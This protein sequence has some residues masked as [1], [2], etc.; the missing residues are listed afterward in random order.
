VLVQAALDIITGFGWVI[1]AARL[2]YK[3]AKFARKKWREWKDAR[4]Q[5]LCGKDPQMDCC[6]N[7]VMAWYDKQVQV[8]RVKE[9]EFRADTQAYLAKSLNYPDQ[10]TPWSVTMF[11]DATD[12]ETLKVLIARE[13]TAGAPTIFAIG[14]RIYS[15][16]GKGFVRR[17]FSARLVVSRMSFLVEF[18]KKK[19]QKRA[20]V[21]RYNAA[22][23]DFL[24]MAGGRRDTQG[25]RIL[26]AKKKKTPLGVVFRFGKGFFKQRTFEMMDEKQSPCAIAHAMC[27]AACYQPEQCDNYIDPEG[28]IGLDSKA[29]EANKK[30][31]IPMCA[32]VGGLAR[33]NG[34]QDS[35]VVKDT[36][37]GPTALRPFVWQHLFKDGKDEAMPRT[38]AFAYAAAV[39]DTHVLPF[40]SCGTEECSIC[41]GVASLYTSSQ[42]PDDWCSTFKLPDSQNQS[43]SY[44]RDL[45]RYFKCHYLT[46]YLGSTDDKRRLSGRDSTTDEVCSS[47]SFCSEENSQ[48]PKLDMRPGLKKGTAAFA[49]S[50]CRLCI[51]FVQR[52]AAGMRPKQFCNAI[53]GMYTQQ[54][55][56]CEGTLHDMM[57]AV[58]GIKDAQERSTL[59]SWIFGWTSQLSG[60]VCNKYCQP[61]V[62][63][64]PSVR[65]S[66]KNP[67]PLLLAGEDTLPAPPGKVTETLQL[68]TEQASEIVKSPMMQRAMK[69]VSTR[70]PLSISASGPQVVIW[71][72]EDHIQ[73]S[74]SAWEAL[75]KELAWDGTFTQKRV[76]PRTSTQGLISRKV[77][78]AVFLM[79][80]EVT[81]LRTHINFISDILDTKLNLRVARLTAEDLIRRVDLLTDNFEAM[82]QVIDSISPTQVPS[83][84]RRQV[85]RK[86]RD[87]ETVVKCYSV[88]VARHEM[89]S[90]ILEELSSA[91][92]Q[93]TDKLM[94][95]RQRGVKYSPKDTGLLDVLTKFYLV[96]PQEEQTR[97]TRLKQW[98]NPFNLF[99]T[100]LKIDKLVKADAKDCSF[101]KVRKMTQ[102][103]LWKEF[104]TCCAERTRQVL[105]WETNI[106][107]VNMQINKILEMMGYVKGNLLTRN[108]R[109]VFK[110]TRAALL[111][112]EQKRSLWIQEEAADMLL[113]TWKDFQKS[114]DDE[115]AKNQERG[116]TFRQMTE[117][118][119]NSVGDRGVRR[120][121]FKELRFDVVK[122]NAQKEI[123]NGKDH[124][125]KIRGLLSSLAGRIAIEED[126]F[127][128]LTVEGIKERPLTKFVLVDTGA[129]EDQPKRRKASKWECEKEA[130]SQLGLTFKSQRFFRSS[131]PAGCLAGE[132][133]KSYFRDKAKGGACG[134]RYK[135]ICAIEP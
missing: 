35:T 88:V 99:R 133:S 69:S 44:A 95:A 14:A 90:P 76:W 131:S 126:N 94:E 12:N 83:K 46:G 127:P 24:P 80:K 112:I 9:A 72:L 51:E 15:R 122:R 87:R 39:C 16:F 17:T 49:D 32:P 113:G 123:Q 18:P 91:L 13:I 71:K 30:N 74:I 92:K 85:Q 40:W 7:S 105:G 125:S 21:L 109:K 60:N 79:L 58:P 73:S 100:R 124:F 23:E 4:K 97:F 3:L 11:S 130:S 50:Q 25:F 101:R 38:E 121:V 45:G 26:K 116:K 81:L 2:S 135:C 115:K 1:T 55:V 37:L 89:Y 104:Q 57:E 114:V 78:E 119:Y 20:R 62:K 53:P 33:A 70:L 48:L 84:L 5:T 64:K 19:R 107:T 110:Y 22:C 66:L 27:R 36:K 10:C 129:C 93:A 59:G 41:Q 82:S 77:R 128:E 102:S 134:T 68:Q 67:S 34:V 65:N 118:M 6:V 61:L 54:K 8:K 103:G 75:L 28:Y 86:A 96:L 43:A 47:R 108:I 117:D 52:A 106:R 111:G 31:L 63:R 132:K 98:L 120:G 56:F 42:K 29:A